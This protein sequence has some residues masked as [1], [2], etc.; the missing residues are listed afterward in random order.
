MAMD[1]RA[2]LK[3]TA[4]AA[5]GYAGASP[6]H[7]AAAP[8][9]ADRVFVINETSNTV[10]VIDPMQYDVESTINL[11]SFDE[12]TRP[13]YRYAATRDSGMDV[14]S[15]PLYH[16]CVRA[17]GAAASPDQALLAVAGRGSGNFY[18]IDTVRHRVLGNVAN[19]LAGPSTNPQRIS[20]G[21]MVGRDPAE[22]AFTRNGHELWV[23]LRGEDRIAIVDTGR[24]LREVGGT[25]SGAVRAFLQTVYGPAQVAF[26][27]DGT[28][29]FIASEKV[30]R[31]DVIRLNPDAN[32]YSRPQ[33]AAMLDITR[34][35]ASGGT[36]RL[37]MAPDGRAVWLVHDLDDAITMI[38]AR[39]PFKAVGHFALGDMARP[40]DVAFV[41]GDGAPIAYVACSRGGPAADSGA[42]EIAIIDRT[43]PAAPKLLKRI[44][45]G[46]VD[47]R[48][49]ATAPSGTR[50]YVAHGLPQAAGPLAAQH[51]CAAFD[52][53]DPYS[54]RL[55]A[56]IPLGSLPLA[57][58]ELPN[59]RSVNVL[60]VRP[61]PG[62]RPA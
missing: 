35:D 13:A 30:A 29:A 56:Q 42:S 46:G 9:A 14:T 28:L 34:A 49:L 31:I 20:S 1:R 27:P 48:A 26:S 54:P 41:R 61:A 5:A 47:A 60:Y 36:A 16:G 33:R 58:G 52:L 39:A 10:C 15:A 50:L 59:A 7:A 45:S 6:A 62:K 3:A 21:V 40:T 11:T 19:P 24:A 18:L 57:S 2:F 55:A 4:A 43:D 51:V 38:S 22:P 44:P 8:G 53:G 32:G 12:D 17:H 23:P 37:R 25:P